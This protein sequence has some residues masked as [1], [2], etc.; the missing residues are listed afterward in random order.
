M[1][2]KMLLFSVAALPAV[3]PARTA[4]QSVAADK[5]KLTAEARRDGEKSRRFDLDTDFRV[6]KIRVAAGAELITIFADLRG[7]NDSSLTD[8]ADVPLVSVLRDTLGDDT[9]TNDRLRYV[10][11][12]SY[13]KPSF[14]QKAA[15]SVPFLYARTTNKRDAGKNPPPPL[16]E[17]NPSKKQV[18]DKI[19]WLA[20]RNLVVPDFSIPARSAIL[21]NRKNADDH[22]KTAVAR[23]ISILSLYESFTGEKVLSEVEMQDIQ[24]RLLL[25]DQLLGSL[26]KSDNLERVY[27]KNVER[28]ED[29]RGHNWELLRQYTEAQGLYFDPLEMPDGS[30]THALV[31]VAA[32]DLAANKNRKFDGRFLNIKNPWTDARLAKWK[33]YTRTRWFDENNREV[34]PDTPNAVRKTLIPLA[35]YGLDYP[36]IPALLVDFRD[37]YNPKKR[38]MSRRVLNDVAQNVLAVSKFGNLT[39]LVGRYAY[40]FLTTQRGI[41]VNQQSRFHSYSQLKLLLSLN[42][43]LEPEFR[44][45]ISERLET[46]SLN[47]LENDLDVEVKMARQ[48]YE[49]LV[50]YAKNPDGLSAKIEKDRR[51][52][53]VKLKHGD[54]A[55]TMFKIANVL[56]LGIYKH[57]EKATPELRSALDTRRRLDYYGRMLR[58]T[59]RNSARPEVD[60]DAEKIK[61]ALGFIAASGAEADAKTAKAVAKIF[62]LTADDE[63]RTLSLNGLYV[64]NNETA[65]NQL[66]E[67]YQTRKLDAQWRDLSR[68]YLKRALADE[69]RITPPDAKAISK[70]SE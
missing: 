25:S 60:G 56:S 47:P 22:R 50:A 63:I 66:L 26:V 67:V 4:A 21:Q 2:A 10:W 5:T 65:K 29:F 30:Q 18:W 3:F 54:G 48:Q 38:E 33:G 58:E 55:Q 69:Q 34:A 62:W 13:T 37:R 9:M 36:K 1:A 16:V 17:L 43:N 44:D 20:F 23:A 35:V 31:W 32:K 57:Y 41:D 45:L 7:L 53:M 12:L 39:Y 40:D 6:E 61:L 51:A 24:A 68:D 11:M 28:T 49:N 64:I 46:V 14:A 27:Q 70:I 8:T 19:F 52:E 59:A 42:S 15:S